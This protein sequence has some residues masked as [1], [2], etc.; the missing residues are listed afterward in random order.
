VR[1]LVEEPDCL[2]HWSGDTVYY[3]QTKQWD[4]W[5]LD[6]TLRLLSSAGG[7]N[8]VG[9]QIEL[10]TMDQCGVWCNVYGDGSGHTPAPTSTR[11][12]RWWSTP[13]PSPGMHIPT[14]A[15]RTTS[16]SR[17]DGQGGAAGKVRVDP[18]LGVQPPG[19]NTLP[20]A[21]RLASS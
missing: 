3:G 7:G 4:D 20:S 21:I 11:S 9:V 12:R 18:A 10:S 17:A 16:R 1:A 8:I 14:A 13:R 15:S 5:F 19:S 2:G 6:Y